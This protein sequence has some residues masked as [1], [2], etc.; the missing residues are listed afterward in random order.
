MK[1]EV[2]G[3]AQLKALSAAGISQKSWSGKRNSPLTQT[4]H[5]NYA[6]GALSACV[7]MKAIPVPS[8]EVQVRHVSPVERLGLIVEGMMPVFGVLLARQGTHIYTP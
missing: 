2:Q 1:P 6:F 8:A 5:R 3:L 7:E 4:Q